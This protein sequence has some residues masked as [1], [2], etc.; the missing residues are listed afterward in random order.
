MLIVDYSNVC[1]QTYSKSA[2]LQSR[3]QL[4]TVII[5]K[6]NSPSLTNIESETFTEQLTDPNE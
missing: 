4:L 5:L 6:K 1:K 2:V 3:A